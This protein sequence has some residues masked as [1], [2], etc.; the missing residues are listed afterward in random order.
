MIKNINQ[1]NG[2]K[3]WLSTINDNFL[4]YSINLKRFKT[5]SQGNNPSFDCDRFPHHFI[6]KREQ[7]FMTRHF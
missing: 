7:S 3:T 5:F 6:P 4:F 1:V 2:L